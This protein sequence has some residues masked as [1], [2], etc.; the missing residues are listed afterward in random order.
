[1]KQK[2]LFCSLLFVVIILAGCSEDSVVEPEESTGSLEFNT[3]NPWSSGQ[4]SSLLLPSMI[5]NPPLIGDTTITETT[6]LKLCIGDVWVSQE[7]A[8]EGQTDNLFHEV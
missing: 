4:Q 8:E 7:E 3:L 1:M 6:S 2:L 5:A